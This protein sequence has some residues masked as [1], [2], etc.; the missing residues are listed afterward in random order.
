MVTVNPH[1]FYLKRLLC[2]TFLFCSPLW[3]ADVQWTY[4]SL[5]LIILIQSGCVAVL[6]RLG[7]PLYLTT[8]EMAVEGAFDHLL[9]L[10]PRTVIR[11]SLILFILIMYKITHICSMLLH[12]SK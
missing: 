4:N 12:P 3:I 9:L 7:S 8:G 5:L 2:Y 6:S 11:F 10:L 1:E